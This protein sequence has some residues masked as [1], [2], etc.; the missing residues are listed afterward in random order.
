[1]A[2]ITI[3]LVCNILS[4][5]PVIV[6]GLKVPPPSNGVIFNSNNYFVIFHVLLTKASIC[7]SIMFHHIPFFKSTYRICT[8][9]ALLKDNN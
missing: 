1:M 9:F 8:L 5:I 4:L 6:L 7:C 3:N 2:C